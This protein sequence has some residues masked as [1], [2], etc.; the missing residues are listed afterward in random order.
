MM[1]RQRESNQLDF[2]IKNIMLACFGIS[3]LWDGITTA[4]GI[5]AIIDAKDI[6]G[7]ALC[8]VGGV[9]ILGFGIGTQVIFVKNDIPHKIMRGLWVLAVAF[10]A[11]T[12][13]MG[14]AQYIVLRKQLAGLFDVVGSLTLGQII[15]TVGLTI[16]VTASPIMISYLLEKDEKAES[17]LPAPP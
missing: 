7:Y 1:N 10:D 11:Y 2:T 14:N 13:F 6:F 4:L 15:I 17:G 3:T 8:F 9:V 12:S 5:A 16:L